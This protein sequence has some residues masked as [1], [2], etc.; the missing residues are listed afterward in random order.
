MC[1]RSI[2]SW[3]VHQVQKVS[4]H[5]HKKMKNTK[6][7]HTVRTALKIQL[8][9]NNLH[10]LIMCFDGANYCRNFTLRKSPS[11]HIINQCKLFIFNWIFKAVRTVQRWMSVQVQGFVQLFDVYNTKKAWIKCRNTLPEFG[12]TNDLQY[13][14]R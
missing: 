6:Q 10:W 3:Q 11:K 1:F 4:N 13:K 7:Y 2:Y 14:G 8:K 12:S 5:F 9:M